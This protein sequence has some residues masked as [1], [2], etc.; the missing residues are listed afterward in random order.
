MARIR[1]AEWETEEYW[2]NRIAAYL[3]GELH[4]Q[5]ALRPRISYVSCEDDRVVG[6][7]ARHLTRDIRVVLDRDSTLGTRSKA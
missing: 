5:H 2:R 1:A 4:P 6:F 7:I 3:R